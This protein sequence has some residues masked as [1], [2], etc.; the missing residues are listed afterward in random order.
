L[1]DPALDAWVYLY[2][3]PIRQ[4]SVVPSGSW[5]QHLSTRHSPLS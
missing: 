2:N 1:T 4:S 3:R 5:I